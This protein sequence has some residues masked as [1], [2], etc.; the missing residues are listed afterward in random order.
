MFNRRETLQMLLAAG[1]AVL[2]GCAGVRRP[3]ATSLSWKYFPADDS[4]FLRAPVLLTGTSEAILI[5]GGFTL[6][7]GRAL[8]AAIQASGKKL[9]TVYVSQSDPDYYF[10]LGPIAQAFPDAR[11][12]AAPA[13][14]AAIKNNVQ[15]KLD[16]WGPLLK[17]NGPQKLSDVVVPV[18][19]DAVALSLDGETI[20]IVD[21]EGMADRRYLWVP[22]LQAVFGGVMT[23][24]GLHVWTADSPTVDERAAWIRALDTMAARRPKI[25]VS[26]HMAPGASTDASSIAYTRD[27]LVAF[28]EEVARAVDSAALIAA[29]RGRYPNAGLGAALDIGAKVVKGEMKWG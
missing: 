4:G 25:V 3:D 21:V 5:D 12:I 1:S 14:V 19:S 18:A 20:E 15:R 28:E 26:G 24:A 16:T 11:V 2:L 6:A 8:A 9:T 27:Y 23:F 10:S 17:D 13:A 29:M 22:S 7:D